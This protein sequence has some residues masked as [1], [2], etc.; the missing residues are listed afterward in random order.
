MNVKTTLLGAVATAGI[1][2]GTVG[3]AAQVSAQEPGTDGTPAAEAQRAPSGKFLERVAEK[4]GISLE[5]LRQAIQDAA[6]D[7]VGEAL[8]NG[9]ITQEQAD[10]ANERID[11]G[12]GLR[13]LF[14]R[15]QDRR[16]HRRDLIRRG[17]VQSA[18]TAL[19]MNAEEL[20]AE[21][22]E[23]NSIADV[24]A[25]QGV[26]LDAVKAQITSDAEAKLDELV[27]AGTL[28]Q[29]RADD[30]LARLTENLDNI[31]NKS[32]QPASQ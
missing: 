8:A 27:A 10:K 32:K 7:A 6:H 26:S 9:R 14:E 2:A 20:R 18:A 12:K 16:E 4:L 21:L 5:Q 23:G 1:I 22:Q 17:I 24:A 25:E 11:S 31:L 28:T 30:A 3:V 19:S 13:G 29:E 15:R